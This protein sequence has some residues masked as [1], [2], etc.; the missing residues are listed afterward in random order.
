[1]L[2]VAAER[3]VRRWSQLTLARVARV[4]SSEL[5]KIEN[6]ILHPYRRQLERLA[7]AL[8]V[9]PPEALLDD[10]RLEVVAGGGTSGPTAREAQR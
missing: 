9:E 1:M 3:L 4:P 8:G 2:R 6:G 5:S 10:V 7:A